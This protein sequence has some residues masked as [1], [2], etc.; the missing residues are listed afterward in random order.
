MS[1][2]HKHTRAQ[3]RSNVG[4]SVEEH[5][6]IN[7]G[8]VFRNYIKKNTFLFLDA[9]RVGW[10]GVGFCVG[11]GPLVTAQPWSSRIDDAPSSKAS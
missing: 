11:V 3:A 1:G 2:Q 8:F 9:P 4:N 6:R 10:G 5:A 7:V